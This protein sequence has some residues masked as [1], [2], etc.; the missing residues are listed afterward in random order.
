MELTVV[1]LPAASSPLE[2]RIYFAAALAPWWAASAEPKSSSR[3]A[4][5]LFPGCWF[6]IPRALLLL[7][8][9]SWK[10]IVFSGDLSERWGQCFSRTCCGRMRGDGLN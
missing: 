2:S 1:S 4:E 5:R 3:T 9:L 8:C 6:P 7:V 10:I